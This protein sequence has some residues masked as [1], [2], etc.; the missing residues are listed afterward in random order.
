MVPAPHTPPQ[1]NCQAKPSRGLELSILWPGDQLSPLLPSSTMI[2]V[3]ATCVA[4]E[5]GLLPP[6]GSNEAPLPS[7]L[8]RCQ[9]RSQGE[10]GLA[11]SPSRREAMLPWVSQRPWGEPEPLHSFQEQGAPSL[12]PLCVATKAE[13]ETCFYLSLEEINRCHL[14]LL[15]E[16]Y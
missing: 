10:S 7:P 15:L 3:R 16:W 5:F 6:P 8:T 1:A 12:P 13:W 14:F 9:R 2:F 11:P 4:C